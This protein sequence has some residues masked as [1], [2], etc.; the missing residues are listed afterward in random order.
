MNI[1]TNK[2]AYFNYSIESEFECGL[3]LVGC[4]VKSIR[5]GNVT[6]SDSFIYIKDGEVW[7]K[8]MKV[9]KYSQ[10]HPLTHHDENRDKKLL[11]KR[12]EIN[13]IEKQLQDKGTTAIPLNIFVKSNLIKIKIGVATGKKLWNKREDIKKKDIEREMK[14]GMV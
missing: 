14:R 10:S 3:V 11:L 8:N 1:V 4:E 13:K 5:M 6:I 9:A 12:K 2:K 7:I